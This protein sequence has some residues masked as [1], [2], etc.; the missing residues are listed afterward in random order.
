MVLRRSTNTLCVVAW[1]PVTDVRL[2]RAIVHG[3]IA[4]GAQFCMQV[5][6]HLE[7]KP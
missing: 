4:R 1:N 7:C 3:Q 2:D 6:Q 5:M